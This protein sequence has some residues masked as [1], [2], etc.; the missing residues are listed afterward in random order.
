M[1]HLLWILVWIFTLTVVGLVFV[2]CGDDSGTASNTD[3]DSDSD[4]DSDTDTD[5][6]TDS[7]G[8]MPELKKFVGN[9]TTSPSGKVDWEE[10]KFADYWDQITP[11][12]AGKWGVVEAQLGDE[13][14][15][16]VL[17]QIYAYAEDEKIFFKQ[18]AFLWGG[19]SPEGASDI[20]EADV[21]NWM[22]DFCDRYAH[23]ALIEV[24]NEPPPHTEPA[25]ADNIGG[26]T[27]G[28]WTWV[29]NA[30]KWARDACPESVLIL[31]DYNNVEDAAHAG[32]FTNIVQTLRF[33]DAPIDAV[34]V[35]A[36]GFNASNT[37]FVKAFLTKLSLDVGLPVYISE[38]GISTEDDNEQLE[39]YQAQMSFF[40]ETEFIAGVTIHGWIYGETPE[41]A[42]YS[43]LLV[44]DEPRPAFT[45]LM[46]TLE[47]TAP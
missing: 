39:T 14:Q 2:A 8:D 17:D 23:T 1:K 40:L 22:T 29:I 43:G 25:F 15:W 19:H 21:K 32:H 34:G 9:F 42:P 4:S 13:R 30:F 28:E 20:Q 27:D 46:E 38:Y 3:S 41:D 35:S 37:D 5:T 6:D 47:R 11:E 7:D 12:H 18:H 16:D 45:W 44:D 36:R 26:G 33:A 10:R 24:V 31:N